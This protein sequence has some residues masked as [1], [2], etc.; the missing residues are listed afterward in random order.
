LDEAA[1]SYRL[2]LQVL[3]TENHSQMYTKA[4]NNLSRVLEKLRAGTDIK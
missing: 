4:S 3:T 1:E 2:A